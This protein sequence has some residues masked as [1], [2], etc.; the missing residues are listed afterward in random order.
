MQGCR[1]NG[2]HGERK[3]AGGREESGKIATSQ[4]LGW[5]DADDS[6]L[7][8]QSDFRPNVNWAADLWGLRP[9]PPANSHRPT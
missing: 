6:D 4:Y 8:L 9:T 7:G 5:I 3:G 1:G 2:G